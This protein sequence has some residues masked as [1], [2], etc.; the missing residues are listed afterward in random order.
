MANFRCVLFFAEVDDGVAFW[1]FLHG[2]GDIP[3]TLQSDT[4][5]DPL[6]GC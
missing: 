6:E 2:R 5:T 1:R 3:P 4:A